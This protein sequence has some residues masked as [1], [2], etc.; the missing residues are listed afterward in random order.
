M[1]LWRDEKELAIAGAAIVAAS[2]FAF[3]L[4]GRNDWLANVG[5]LVLG[6]L[7]A[8]F[9]T[10]LSE[11]VRRRT[12]M[13]DLARALHVEL[14]D[15]VARCCFDA[16]A[17]WNAWL[18]IHGH[19]SSVVNSFRLRKFIPE[20]PIVY[21]SSAAQLALLGHDAAQ[22]L[23]KFYYRLAAW[24]RDLENIAAKS[25]DYENVETNDLQLLAR[26]LRETLRPGLMAL[27][28]MEPLLEGNDAVE[29]S[30]IA[31]YDDYR[32]DAKPTHGLRNRLR[33]LIEEF[34][35]AT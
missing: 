28:A 15:R 31:G 3:G 21:L 32:A 29:A 6:T 8:V 7:I 23:I 18:E 17:P 19:G 20:N 11:R 14:A 5:F 22:A 1:K 30:A 24:R 25:D 10:L 33:A 4:V 26:R 16:E 35:H 27:E 12:Q 2:T 13:R 9:T 34:P